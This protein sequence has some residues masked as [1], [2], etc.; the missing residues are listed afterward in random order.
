VAFSPDDQY[1]AAC[2]SGA[3]SLIEIRNVTTRK[4]LPSLRGHDWAIW[5]VAFNPTSEVPRLASGSADGTVGIWDM[6]AGREMVTPRLRRTSDVRCLAFSGDGGFLASG[7]HDRIIKIWDARAWKLFHE[8]SDPTGGVESVAF[9]PKD[10]QILAW[11]AAD[12]TVKI[13]N[14]ATQKT[15]T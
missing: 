9:H 7:G 11:G 14:R 15:H 6:E 4:E 5:D 2:K 12:S 13:W 10:S 3:D 8:L 1:L